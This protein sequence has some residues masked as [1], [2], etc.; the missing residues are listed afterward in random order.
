[1]D[2][3]LALAILCGLGVLFF[4]RKNKA[5]DAQVENLETKEKVLQLEK[6]LIKTKADLE[7]EETKRE[8]LKKEMTEKINESLTPEDIADY[9]N[10]RK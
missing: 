7:L 1:V 5:S 10:R 4:L 8:D 6:E 2:S 9:F 3:D